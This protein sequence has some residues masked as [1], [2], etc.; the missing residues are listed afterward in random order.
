[1]RGYVR[2][3]IVLCLL[4]NCFLLLGCGDQRHFNKGEKYLKAGMYQEAMNEFDLVVK[5]YPNSDYHQS[6]EQKFQRTKNFLLA[7]R[8]LDE[9][10]QLDK[11]GSFDAAQKRYDDALIFMIKNNLNN[12]ADVDFI[13]GR[14]EELQ[15]LK[16]DDYLQRGDRYMTDN[17][18]DEALKEYNRAWDFSNKDPNGTI[19]QKINFARRKIIIEALEQ[20]IREAEALQKVA[21]PKPAPRAAQP[22]QPKKTEIEIIRPD[23]KT[24]RGTT[25]REEAGDS[26]IDLER[27]RE[28]QR[29]LSGEGQ[30]ESSDLENIAE[31]LNIFWGR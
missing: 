17:L 7:Q 25:S 19:A 18:Y 13:R 9:A 30:A 16:I 5:K 12:K 28:L 22:A 24:R 4:G 6:A 2:R 23:A 10:N 21:Q 14:L 29:R 26:D 11:Q 15:Q 31:Q 8:M 3:F 1:M 20:K 27:L